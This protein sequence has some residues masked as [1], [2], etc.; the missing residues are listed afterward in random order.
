VDCAPYHYISPTTDWT[1]TSSD[2]DE[3]ASSVEDN[4]GPTAVIDAQQT[5]AYMRA[6]G[7]QPL[8]QPSGGQGQDQG[9][10][11]GDSGTQSLN[12]DTPSTQN[13]DTGNVCFTINQL[14][15]N[16]KYIK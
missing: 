7:S 12:P 9:Q 8:P 11:P 15:I 5:D 2:E 14:H 6:T 16:Y 10:V 1:S 4:D 3:Q 13:D